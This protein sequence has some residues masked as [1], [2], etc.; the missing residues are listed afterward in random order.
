MRLYYKGKVIGMLLYQLTQWME[1]RS[2]LHNALRLGTEDNSF[3]QMKIAEVEQ[4]LH[5]RADQWKEAIREASY[6]HIPY[7]APHLD[8]DTVL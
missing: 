8:E 3:I 1:E 7:E 6:L 2:A 4:Q 5:Q